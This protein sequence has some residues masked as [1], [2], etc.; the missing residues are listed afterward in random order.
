LS[1][2][3][4][5]RATTT[6]SPTTRRTSSTHGRRLRR[7]GCRPR[8]A[9]VCSRRAGRLIWSAGRP[10]IVERRFRSW[11]LRRPGG[12]H[13]EAAVAAAAAAAEG[14]DAALLG[15]GGD[16]IGA[17]GA[18]ARVG[19][20]R[21]GPLGGGAHGRGHPSACGSLSGEDR[22][23]KLSCMLSCIYTCAR[24]SVNERFG[25][26]VTVDQVD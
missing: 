7:P 8:A 13:R 2:R 20:G 9:R 23:R 5:C 21:C 25:S 24:L 3:P 10:R 22:L 11:S 17:T 1:P 6:A 18:W 19:G 26:R 15:G 16:C 12:A 4:R 14:T